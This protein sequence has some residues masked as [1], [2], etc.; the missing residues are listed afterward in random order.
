MSKLESFAPAAAAIPDNR[1]ANL[2]RADPE[3]ARLLALYLPQPLFTHL[4]PHFDRLGA[5]AGGRLDELAALADRNPPTLIHRTRTGLDEQRI[6]KHPAYVEMERIAF[7]EYGLAA[8]SHRGG[9]LG[10]PEPMPPA[11]KY[12]L[13]YL[14]VQAEFGL[15]CPVSMTD[16]AH[17]NAEEVRC[18]GTR[19]ALPPGAHQPGPRRTVPGRDVHDRAG[20]GIGRRRDRHARGARRRRHLAPVRRQMVLLERRCGTRDGAG[21]ARWRARRHAR[22]RAVPAAEDGVRTAC[23]TAT[24]SCG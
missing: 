6:D 9:V 5:L 18:P 1:G 23:R 24:A 19:R 10:W 2:Y 22:R 4:E 12:A 11:A 21:A 13:T 16:S 17:A 8:L 14:F 3:Y 20:R 7:G 15:C